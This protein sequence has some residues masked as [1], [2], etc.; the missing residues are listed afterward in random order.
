MAENDSVQGNFFL[1]GYEGALVVFIYRF[2]S[3]RTMFSSPTSR[4]TLA[5]A[6]TNK[7]DTPSSRLGTLS[8]VF[9]PCL[10]N[11]LGVIL[12]LRLPF[13]VAQAGCVHTSIIIVT[14]VGS[15]F[16][17]SLSLSAIASNGTIRAGGPYYVLSRTLGFEVGASLGVLFYL[18]TSINEGIATRFAA[19][20]HCHSILILPICYLLLF[21]TAVR[22]LHCCYISAAA[23][24]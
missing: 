14:C 23:P 4:K 21:P 1:S 11:I 16:L 18:A 22:S 19:T 9:L 17:T 13:I 7:D 24:L 3:K 20:C 5:D 6:L 15:T 2:N 10:Q 8:G 12:F